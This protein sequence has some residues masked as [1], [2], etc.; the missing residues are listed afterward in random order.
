MVFDWETNKQLLPL[1]AGVGR[2]F[3]IGRQYVNSFVEPAWNVS[4]DGPAPRY[5]IT[6]G[7]SLLYPDFWGSYAT[8]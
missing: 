1:D 7:F 3:A 6:F 8:R 2:V 4:H 5:A